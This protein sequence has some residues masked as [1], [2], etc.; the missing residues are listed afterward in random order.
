MD[1]Q[2]EYLRK[3]IEL[4]INAE[5]D[6]VHMHP[7]PCQ[8]KSIIA[9]FKNEKW[10]KV[11]CL[12][13]ED[14][15][16][17]VVKWGMEYRKLYSKVNV[18]REAFSSSVFG[19][20]KIVGASATCTQSMCD[21]ILGM[22]NISKNRS[23]STKMSPIRPNIFVKVKPFSKLNAGFFSM[24]K[25][26]KPQTTVMKLEL[27]PIISELINDFDAFKKTL[28]FVNRKKVCGDMMELILMEI[29]EVDCGVIVQIHADVPRHIKEETFKARQSQ[30][31][32]IIKLVVFLLLVRVLSRKFCQEI[33]FKRMKKLDN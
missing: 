32:L 29:D 13:F 3:K 30:T 16:H 19:M 33:F 1:I 21:E 15:V 22:H 11:K 18:I 4:F 31:T 26:D 27:K 5:V 7:E 17:L 24:G 2:N 20:P 9:I 12:I 28:I 8:D 23:V 14:E 25:V 6:S 10:S